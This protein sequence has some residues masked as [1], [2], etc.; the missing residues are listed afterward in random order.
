MYHHGQLP[1]C[2]FV[3]YSGTVCLYTHTH[4]HTCMHTHTHTQCLGLY[5][6]CYYCPGF[7]VGAEALNSGPHRCLQA[8]YSV[9]CLPV[10][11]YNLKIKFHSLKTAMTV[12]AL[13]VSVIF[14]QWLSSAYNIGSRRD[15]GFVFSSEHGS[16]TLRVRDG[17]VLTSSCL[18]SVLVSQNH[19]GCWIMPGICSWGW[20][21]ENVS[22]HYLLSDFISREKAGH[23]GLASLC[24]RGKLCSEIKWSDKW[25]LQYFCQDWKRQSVSSLGSFWK[26][27]Q[28]QTWNASWASLVGLADPMWSC[29]LSHIVLCTAKGW[30]HWGTEHE[31]GGHKSFFMLPK[32]WC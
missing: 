4:T 11:E 13:A 21:M 1:L 17:K 28:T 9:S 19:I 10:P 25:L 8:L 7:E 16:A 5:P 20:T 31:Q 2:M 30:K 6:R 26:V 32:F 22:W 3:Y 29:Q 23:V 27:G 14:Y 18:T 24:Q 12:L 15:C